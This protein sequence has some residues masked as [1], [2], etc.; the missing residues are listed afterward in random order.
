MIS[1]LAMRD[2]HSN[3]PKPGRQF[4]NKILQDKRLFRKFGFCVIL[5]LSDDTE[6]WKQI[7]IG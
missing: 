4:M 7:E 1:S 5:E 3:L 6:R 2:P